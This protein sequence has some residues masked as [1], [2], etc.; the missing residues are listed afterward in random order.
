MQ[1]KIRVLYTI[2]N[3]DT[4]GSGKSVYD[5]VNGLDRSIFEPEIC[6]FHNKGAF[7]KEVEKL[8]VKIHIFSFTT[9][10]TP[11]AS[12]IFRVLKI[13][14]FFKT[15][16]FDLIHSWHWSSDISEPLAAKLAGIP[17]V[18][19]KKAMGWGNKYWSW[20]S[21]LSKKVIVVNQDMI[22]QY[23]SNMAHKIVKFPLA[24]DTNRYR[25]NGFESPISK[26]TYFKTE[27]FVILSIANL[28]AVKGIE[29]LFQAV[30][31]LNDERIKV[32]IVGNDTNDY[33]VDLKQRY[34][35]NKNI[36]FAGKQ[37]EVRPFLDL[38]DLFVIPTKDEGR[39]EGIP[40]APLEA[41]AT[42][43]VVLGSNVSG[44]KD[45]LKE[46]PDCLFQAS[47]VD[48]LAEKI[49]WI[50]TMSEAKRQSLGEAMRKQVIKE[51]SIEEFLKNHERLYLSMVN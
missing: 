16:N 34:A 46:F 37:L 32:L 15:H 19:T 12:F 9:K 5:L 33:G 45:I 22:E 17:Y 40:N 21:K 27:D 20:R 1:K 7:F 23:F 25:P 8:D 41:M 31:K 49:L 30:E 48:E 24:I 28:V 10:Y 14:K 4:A 29:I 2:P 3:F 36:V 11:K 26:T 35:S 39:R 18:Y 51:F 47:N 6:C 44:V 50:K 43:C 13:K 42:N 38:A